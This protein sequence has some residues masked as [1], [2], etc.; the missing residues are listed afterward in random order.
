MD[1]WLSSSPVEVNGV[2]VGRINARLLADGRIEFA[3]TPSGGERILPPS[4]YFPTSAAIDIWL[5]STE[6]DVGGG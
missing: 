3:F 1:R 2:G 4:R 6:I 5:R